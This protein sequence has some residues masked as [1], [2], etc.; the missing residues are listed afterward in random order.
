M[1]GFSTALVPGGEY[2]H[3]AEEQHTEQDEQDGVHGLDAGDEQTG[4]HD[5]PGHRG[6]G[7]YEQGPERPPAVRGLTSNGLGFRSGLRTV[8]SVVAG[9][10][11]AS[12]SLAWLSSAWR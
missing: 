5:E 12:C 1:S 11:S 8:S 7:R 6:D 10:I 2:E 3:G 4:E 9:A